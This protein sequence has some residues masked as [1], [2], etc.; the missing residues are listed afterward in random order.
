MMTAVEQTAQQQF[1]SGGSI[2]VNLLNLCSKLISTASAVLEN[3]PQKVCHTH[4][5][6]AV[7]A[8]R[9]TKNYIFEEI[10][11]KRLK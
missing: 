10:L 11:K 5:C 7:G 2:T 3:P 1:I 8:G 4:S 9:I 6:R